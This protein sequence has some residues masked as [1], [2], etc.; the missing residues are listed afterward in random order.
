MGCRGQ[1][2]PRLHIIE[3]GPTEFC[4]VLKLPSLARPSSA[5]SENYGVWFDRVWPSLKITEFGP[6]E[7]GPVWK[8]PFL[9]RPSLTQS[10]SYRVFIFGVTF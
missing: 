3:F 7:F 9:A 5:Q 4:P 1:V 8:L 10:G 6:T 2:W